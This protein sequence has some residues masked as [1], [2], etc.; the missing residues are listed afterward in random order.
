MFPLICGALL[1][2]AIHTSST[3]RILNLN[4]I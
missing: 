4:K 2:N 1:I 3:N